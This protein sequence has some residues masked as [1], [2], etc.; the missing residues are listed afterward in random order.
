MDYLFIKWIHIVSATIL[1]GTGL[2]SAF[3]LF[4]AVKSKNIDAITFATF[5]VV[6]A[7]WIFTTPAFI[8]QIMSGWMLTR[9]LGFEL[10][11]PWLVASFILI[12]ITGA[13]WLP[14]LWIQYQLRNT[15]SEA[16]SRNTPLS[17]IF[18]KLFRWWISLGVIA[19]TSFLVIF[20]LMIA[21]PDI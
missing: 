5:W 13:C 17:H 3:Y 18:H 11:E 7:D 12:S 21:K 9:Q 4:V 16:Q 1:F 2:G 6:I 10:N 8:I 19:F 15:A 20:Y 14:V